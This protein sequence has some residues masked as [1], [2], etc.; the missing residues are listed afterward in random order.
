LGRCR[1]RGCKE[2][3][4]RRKREHRKISRHGT[5]SFTDLVAGLAK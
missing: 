3:N 2:D 4:R 5:I 1:M